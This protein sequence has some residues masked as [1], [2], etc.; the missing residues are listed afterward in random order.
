MKFNAQE[1]A[2]AKRDRGRPLYHLQFKDGTPY[3]SFLEMLD[4]LTKT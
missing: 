3:M 4:A 1:L 2:T